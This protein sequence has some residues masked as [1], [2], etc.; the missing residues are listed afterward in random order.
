[1]AKSLKGGGQPPKKQNGVG[2]P[3][4]KKPIAEVNKNLYERYTRMAKDSVRNPD[5]AKLA[6]YYK[7][8]YERTS[9]K[10]GYTGLGAIPKKK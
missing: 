6:A 4:P 9:K 3:A 8:E 5:A 7:K 2:S 10:G 1:M